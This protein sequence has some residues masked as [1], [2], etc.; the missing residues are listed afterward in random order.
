LGIVRAH[1]DDI[2]KSRTALGMTAVTNLYSYCK[3]TQLSAQ[4]RA[5]RGLTAVS[6]T[7][8]AY[9]KACIL[10]ITSQFTSTEDLLFKAT[11]SV[12]NKQLTIQQRCHTYGHQCASPHQIPWTTRPR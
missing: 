1:C 11:K 4:L 2:T 8:V 12:P 3:I 9:S 7:I 10:R 6:A 5:Y